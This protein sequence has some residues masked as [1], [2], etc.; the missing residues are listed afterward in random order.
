MEQQAFGRVFRMGQ[1]KETYLHRI[2]VKNSIDGRMLKLQERKLKEINAALKDYDPAKQRLSES[3]V[4]G[5]FGR[6]TRKANGQLVVERDYEDEEDTAYEGDTEP[7]EDYSEADE[8]DAGVHDDN[9]DDER[10][11][12]SD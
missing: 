4:A 7:Y 2:M 6:I 1:T 9:N 11:E 8:D 12:D 10:D 3:D 5:L